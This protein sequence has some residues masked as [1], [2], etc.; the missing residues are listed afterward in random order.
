MQLHAVSYAAKV[1]IMWKCPKCGR[2]FA[3]RNQD[4]YRV[5]PQSIDEYIAAQDGVMK[6][7][8]NKQMCKNDIPVVDDQ[9]LE[10]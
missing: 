9:G 7:I 6:S 1:I 4:H 8:Q 2:E 5:K 3:R 10:I